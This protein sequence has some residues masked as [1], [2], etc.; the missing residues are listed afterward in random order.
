MLVCNRLDNKITVVPASNLWARIIYLVWCRSWNSGKS[1]L[2]WLTIAG[3][4]PSL[5]AS[6]LARWFSP[7]HN[8]PENWNANVRSNNINNNNDYNN[9]IITR[10]T[11]HIVEFT[12][13]SWFILWFWGTCCLAFLAAEPLL[14]AFWMVQINIIIVLLPVCLSVKL[15]YLRNILRLM[16]RNWDM[17]QII[18]PFWKCW[19]MA[20]VQWTSRS[21]CGLENFKLLYRKNYRK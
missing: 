21:Q 6:C 11:S 8:K 13:F 12:V 10:H 7:F 16:T 19:M 3:P 9:N 5:T 18:R 14:S 4:S 17:L 20:T 1:S 2:Q 15:L